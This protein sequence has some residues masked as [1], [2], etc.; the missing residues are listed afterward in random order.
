MAFIFLNDNIL[1]HPMQRGVT[2]YWQHITKGIITEFGSDVV[3]RSPQQHDF[4]KAKHIIP[5]PIM[6]LRHLRGFGKLGLS[7]LLWRM[8]AIF[9]DKELKRSGAGVILNAYY[10]TPTRIGT[11]RQIFTVY[12]MIHELYFAKQTITRH[13]SE[14]FIQEK[15]ISLNSAALL[16]AIS[17][18]TAQD[19]REINPSISGN[20][21]VVTHLGVDDLFFK[22]PHVENSVPFSTP[23]I[24]FVG[25]RSGYKNFIRFLQAYGRIQMPLKLDLKVISPVG[26]SF[27]QEEQAIITKY[28]IQDQVQLIT[29]VSEVELRAAYTGALMF[30]YPSIY[31]GFGLPI[32]EAMASGTIVATS[33]SSSM[34]EVGGDVA[35][36]FDPLDIDSMAHVM[37]QVAELSAEARMSRIIEG[38]AR[39]REFTWARCQEQTVQAIKS[40]L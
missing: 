26:S 39:A 20:H 6:Q 19:I 12:D 33:N 17:H 23:Y 18:S 2:R 22:S 3:V 21:I 1:S 11:A 31:E 24:L 16:L 40:L 34:P 7:R 25:H 27:T 38:V 5:S 37:F 28:Q 4:G 8:D 15:T 14:T 9:V 32:L 36:Y 35:L 13:A 10:G 29:A 30:V